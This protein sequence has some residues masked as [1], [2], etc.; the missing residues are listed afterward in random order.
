M[1]KAET[2]VEDPVGTIDP[3]ELRLP[4][5]QHRNVCRSTRTRD[6]LDSFGRCYLSGASDPPVIDP[7]S[8]HPRGVEAQE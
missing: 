5:I 1:T 6:L 4:E 3:G 7:R 2:T 8:C